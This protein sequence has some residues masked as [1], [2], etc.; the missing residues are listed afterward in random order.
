VAAVELQYDP[1]GQA[2]Q[3]PALGFAWYVPAAQAVQLVADAAEYWPAA[4]AEQEVPAEKV[5]ATQAVHAVAEAAEF[6][7]VAQ[8]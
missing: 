4:H 2:V 7:P 1:L 6:E 8:D 3:L 5:P